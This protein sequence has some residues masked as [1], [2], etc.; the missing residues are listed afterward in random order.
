M[1]DVIKSSGN[2][3]DDLEV[4]RP[5]PEEMDQMTHE[6]TRA[7]RDCRRRVQERMNEEEPKKRWR[8]DQ[9]LA[10]P[11]NPNDTFDYKKWSER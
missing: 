1:T 2:V 8:E 6:F 5:T 7:M 3:F 11:S 4:K 10:L 9:H